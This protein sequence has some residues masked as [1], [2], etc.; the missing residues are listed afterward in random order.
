MRKEDRSW[1]NQTAVYISDPKTI[2][3]PCPAN[4][5]AGLVYFFRPKTAE[6]TPLK[7]MKIQQKTSL[8]CLHELLM[9][10]LINSE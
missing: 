10:T 9:E 8:P 6:E 7:Y 4:P 3:L 5:N 1:K 2:L